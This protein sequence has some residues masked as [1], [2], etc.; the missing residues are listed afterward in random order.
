MKG[1]QRTT[2]RLGNSNYL[3]FN[4]PPMPL[5]M[6]IA[7]AHQSTLDAYKWREKSMLDG[8]KLWRLRAE[9]V[10]RTVPEAVWPFLRKEGFTFPESVRVLDL[11]CGEGYKNDAIV[12]MITAYDRRATIKKIDIHGID[13]RQPKKIIGPRDRRAEFTYAQLAAEDIGN[14][15]DPESFD[16][17]T[18]IAMHHHLHPQSIVDVPNQ[19]MTLLKPNGIHVVA[20]NFFWDGNKLEQQLSRRWIKFYQWLEGGGFYNECTCK[21]ATEKSHEAG[22]RILGTFH[23]PLFVEG[24]VGRKGNSVC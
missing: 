7:Q 16:L 4:A 18:G 22:F 2:Y 15:F 19:V 3:C 24:F 8:P 12:R 6:N 23:T 9:I 10:K 21:Y 14:N 17:I 5:E 20:D 11:G 13:L 1:I